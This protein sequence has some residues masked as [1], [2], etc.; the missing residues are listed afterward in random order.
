MG[1]AHGV[2]QAIFTGK[3]FPHHTVK[4]DAGCYGIGGACPYLVDAPLQAAQ[5][6]TVSFR[7]P[8]N[9]GFDNIM[10]ILFESLGV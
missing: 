7:C 9:Q 4:F 3:R 10:P 8:G 5:M 1:I 2:D 6:L